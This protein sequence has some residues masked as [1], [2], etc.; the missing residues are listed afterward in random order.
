MKTNLSACESGGMYYNATIE[1]D[2]KNQRAFGLTSVKDGIELSESY[3]IKKQRI[4]NDGTWNKK[5]QIYEYLKEKI[6]YY[7]HE[8]GIKAV[9]PTIKEAVNFLNSK[10]GL[11]IIYEPFTK[12][13]T[14]SYTAEQKLSYTGKNQSEI[15]LMVKNKDVKIIEVELIKYLKE[16]PKT[17]TKELQK[18][19]EGGSHKDFQY[20]LLSRLCHDY[21]KTTSPL[22]M[23]ESG[24]VK[25]DPNNNY[26]PI[27]KNEGWLITPQ[28]EEFLINVAEELK[29]D[30]YVHSSFY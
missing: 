13:I 25:K 5:K 2:E 6:D 14:D 29:K 11:N 27:I 24:P 22:I 9:F 4:D 15:D 19:F 10:Y 23:Q 16:N 18:L 28:A 7:D 8:Q 12:D 21:G 17:S 3:L 30:G 1:T 26:E 20:S